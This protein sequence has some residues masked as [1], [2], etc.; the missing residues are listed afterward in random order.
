MFL[1][2]ATEVI[3][4]ALCELRRMQKPVQRVMIAGGGNIGQRVAA[5]LQK[6]YEVEDHRAVAG[7]RGN[8]WP[9]N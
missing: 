6:R 8:P 3:R 4:P 7:P 2:A 5:R 9:T 1:L